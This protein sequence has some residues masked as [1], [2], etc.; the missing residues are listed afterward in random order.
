MLTR[1]APE[2]LSVDTNKLDVI[3]AE[4]LKKTDLFTLPRRKVSVERWVDVLRIMSISMGGAE[5]TP[6]SR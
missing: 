1:I 3:T 2:R 4:A 6:H 5:K